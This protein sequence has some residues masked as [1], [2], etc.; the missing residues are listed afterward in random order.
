MGKP[1]QIVSFPGAYDENDPRSYN[2]SIYIPGAPY[3]FL[4]RS[5]RTFESS[6][7]MT[8]V[9]YHFVVA[10]R[11]LIAIIHRESRYSEPMYTN[12]SDSGEQPTGQAA[13]NQVRKLCK[14]QN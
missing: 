14:L 12:G 8:V 3:S 1:N 4:V 11:D 2:T 5:C 9:S 13:L 7:E 10:M 6:A